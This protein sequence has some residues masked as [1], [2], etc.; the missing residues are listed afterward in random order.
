[1]TMNQ[2]LY[3]ISWCLFFFEIPFIYVAADKVSFQVT[4]LIDE[5]GRVTKDL[6]GC[7]RYIIELNEKLV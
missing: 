2:V 7:K 5:L 1:M 4:L 6:G 3:V